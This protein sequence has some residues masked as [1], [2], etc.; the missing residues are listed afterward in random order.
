MSNSEVEI[1]W[2]NGTF[3]KASE[4]SNWLSVANNAGI[5]I[6]TGCLSG[7]CGACEMEVDGKIVRACINN[8]PFSKSKKVK[9]EFYS[10]PFW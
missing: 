7:S 1:Q 6:P 2:P 8:I 4:G 5:A 10:D 3:S 9:V